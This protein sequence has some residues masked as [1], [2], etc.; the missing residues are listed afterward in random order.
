M[1]IRLINGIDDPISGK[2][3][4][5]RF[6]ELFPNADIVLLKNCGHYLHVETPI[7]AT[8]I[9]PATTPHWVVTKW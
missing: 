5:D 2:H 1:P 6:A 8:G 4:A 9:S 3:L 7:P